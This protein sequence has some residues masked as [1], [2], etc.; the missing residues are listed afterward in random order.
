MAKYKF[1]LKSGSHSVI[2]SDGPK[3]TVKN[4]EPGD[5]F[6]TDEDMIKLH[7]P[8]RWQNIEEDQ[9]ESIEELRAKLRILEGRLNMDKPKEPEVAK[10]P[11][12]AEMDGMTIKA[13]RALAAN[14]DP[15]VDITA[16]GNKD[17]IMQTLAQTFD[18]A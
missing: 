5:V 15:P 1:K 9:G 14:N 12:L 10:K 3:R 13:L 2:T 4:Y 8:Q 11:T 16:C 7:G 6:E 18:V 17:E